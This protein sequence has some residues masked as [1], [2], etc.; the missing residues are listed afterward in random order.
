MAL[1]DLGLTLNHQRN[2]T[3]KLS[4]EL[5]LRVNDRLCEQL[6]NCARHVGLESFEFV[7]FQSEHRLCEVFDC[8]FPVIVEPSG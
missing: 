8:S 4:Q 2:H 6:R 3:R 7:R 1:A 5:R